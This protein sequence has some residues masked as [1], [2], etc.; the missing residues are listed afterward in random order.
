MFLLLAV[1]GISIVACSDD[2]VDDGTPTEFTLANGSESFFTEGMVFSFDG[3]EQTIAFTTN[4]AWKAVVSQ[5]GNEEGWCTLS[6]NSGEAGEVQLTVKVTTN[7]GLSPREVIITLSVGEIERTV[8]V[9]QAGQAEA[10]LVVL[11]VAKAGT[12]PELIGEE[13]KYKIANL[14]LTGK[15]DGTDLRFIVREMVGVGPWD[16]YE[17]ENLPYAL[18]S[19]DLTD[20]QIVDGGDFYYSDGRTGPIYTTDNDTLPYCFFKCWSLK[21]VKWPQIKKVGKLAFRACYNLT[22]VVIPEGVISIGEGAFEDCDSLTSVVIPESVTNIENAAFC[23]CKNLTSIDIPKSVTT[24]GY[25][26]FGS[27]TNLVSIRIPEGVTSIE[28]STFWG[29]SSLASIEIPEGVTSIGGAAFNGCSSLTSMKIPTGVTSIGDWAFAGCSNLVSIEI[30]KSVTSIDNR[31]FENCSS[32]VSIEIPED[33]T[34]I[35]SNVFNGCNSL[36]EIHLRHSE[37]IDKSYFY[38]SNI[39]WA[40]VTLY[41]PRGSLAA[42]QQNSMWNSFLLDFKEIVEE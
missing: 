36:R 29:C 25:N 42:Y 40:N 18:E 39:D 27:C 9:Q 12:L 14:K 21:E 8:T 30:P 1:A 32:L 16:S 22:S 38:D 23:N 34:L 31:A 28:S 37:P 17:Y 35:G 41:I 13:N 6:A 20:V 10:D 15:L 11:N 5:T 2:D 26:A 33:V 4:K 3:G 7:A 24:I 19:L